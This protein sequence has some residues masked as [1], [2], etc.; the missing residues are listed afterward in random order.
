MIDKAAFFK[1]ERIFRAAHRK[2]TCLWRPDIADRLVPSHEHM[3]LW[4]PNFGFLPFVVGRQRA[5]ISREQLVL[6]Q[7]CGGLADELQCLAWDRR[8]GR[9]R[10]RASNYSKL[11]PRLA[12]I[13]SLVFPPIYTPKYTNPLRDA[14]SAL[15]PVLDKLLLDQPAWKRVQ[16]SLRRLERNEGRRRKTAETTISPPLVSPTPTRLFK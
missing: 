7:L 4:R 3:N 14:D 1:E 2:D 8:P 12:T 5:P 15:H 16:K 13:Q 10:P 9:R 6:A 11:G